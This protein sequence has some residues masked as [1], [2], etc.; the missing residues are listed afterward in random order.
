MLKK[1]N[2]DWKNIYYNEHID[3][4]NENYQIKNLSFIVIVYEKKN[5]KQ[6]KMF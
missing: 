3:F 5:L 4:S 6:K 2:M 1:L